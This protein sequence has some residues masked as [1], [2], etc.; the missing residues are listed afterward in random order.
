VKICARPAA[1]SDRDIGELRRTA[2]MVAAHRQRRLL[3]RADP[4]LPR[5]V[6]PDD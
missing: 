2:A 4:V 5:I 1:S 6:L 3:Y